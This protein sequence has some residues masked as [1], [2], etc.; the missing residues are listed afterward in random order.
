MERFN[1]QGGLVMRITQ[2]F[3]TLMLVVMLVNVIVFS[4]AVVSDDANTTA[5][6]T[7]FDPAGSTQTAPTSINTAGAIT[8]DYID[9]NHVYH[10]FVRSPRGAFTTFDGPGSTVTQANSINDAGDHR[11]LS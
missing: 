8:V 6:F 7:T 11:V 3:C 4:Q 2:R 5:T 10:G 9:A 1:F